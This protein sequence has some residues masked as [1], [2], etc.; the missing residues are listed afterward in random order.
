MN[1]TGPK[2]WVANPVADI[3]KNWWADDVDVSH[4]EQ[5]GQLTSYL[6]A[7]PRYETLTMLDEWKCMG[8]P[9]TSDMSRKAVQKLLVR[10]D[11]KN[12]EDFF[13]K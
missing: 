3:L 1:A 11:G 13:I 7:E 5:P 9:E 4:F 8:A 2:A 10:R 12:W 6:A